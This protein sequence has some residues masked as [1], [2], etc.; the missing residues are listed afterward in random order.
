MRGPRAFARTL[1]RGA[2]ALWPRGREG[3]RGGSVVAGA[4]NAQAQQLQQQTVLVCPGSPSSSSFSS[5]A[6]SSSSSSPSSSAVLLALRKHFLPVSFHTAAWDMAP[7]LD[8]GSG[9][10]DGGLLNSYEAEP[11]RVAVIGS[12]NWGSVAARL[13]ATNARRLPYF[14]DEVRVWVYEEKLS[15]GELLSDVI[16]KTQENV[17]YLPNVKLGPNVVA[18]PN[19]ETAVKNATMLVFVMPHQFI[20]GICQ[21]L[22]GK[23]RPDAKA[24]SLIK[25]MEM[26]DDGPRLISREISEQLGIDCSVLMGAN[27]ANEIAVE[28]FSEATVGYRDDKETADK[29]VQVFGTPYF[30]VTHVQ[31]VEGVELCGTLKNIVAIAAGLVDG[32][33][34]GNN[35]KAAIMR[36]GLK[37]M[38]LFSKLLFPSVQDATFFESCGIADLITTCLGGRN[39]KVA[40]AF[41]K[42]GGKRSFDELEVELLNGQKLQGVLTA[43]EVFGLLKA[44]DWEESF[45]L[46]STVHAIATRHLP[47]SAIVEYSERAPRKIV[48][49]PEL[50]L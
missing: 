17:K 36:I 25:G 50:H 45:P 47:P 40:D 13:A 43:K 23:I 46:F 39:R 6:S 19:L 11:D 9:T 3:A 30:Q 38:I 35:T 18:D 49:T 37:E 7:G 1:C 28:Q 20:E 29:W 27:I 14:Q 26:G 48:G 5:S 8:V 2:P 16:N 22:K 33:G 34:M 24:I 44:K 32:L 10:R 4:K 12:G 21:K 31:D 42:H 41:S 15:N